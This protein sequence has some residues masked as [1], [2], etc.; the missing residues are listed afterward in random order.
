MNEDVSLIKNEVIFQLAILV[1]RAVQ[2]TVY[3]YISLEQTSIYK[4]LFQL[5]DLEPLL[6]KRVVSPNIHFKLVV[7]SPR[8]PM[9]S[10][11]EGHPPKTMPFQIKTRGPTWGSRYTYIFFYWVYM[12]VLQSSLNFLTFSSPR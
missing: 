12:P 3:I 10:I 9:T 5:D 4:W 11:F 6:G 2:Y 1:F 8:A 7:W